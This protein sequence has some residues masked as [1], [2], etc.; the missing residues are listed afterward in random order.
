MDFKDRLKYLI[1]NK[2]VNGRKITP[3]YLGKNTSVSR[4]S[5]ENYISGKQKPTINNANIIAQFFNVSVDWLLSGKDDIDNSKIIGSYDA[6]ELAQVPFISIASTAGFVET[7][8]EDDTIT[9][10]I[11]VQGYTQE[12][13]TQNGYIAI[14]VS[15]HSMEPT[16]KDKARILCKRVNIGDWDY[17][18][19]GIYVIGY[20][21]D[22]LVTKRVK[23]NDLQTKG[24]LTLYSDNEEYGVLTVK[25]DSI[26]CIWQGIEIIRQKLI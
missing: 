15:G 11:A 18:H 8:C 16:I 7:F 23:E 2:K 22:M 24:T 26:R 17:I 14:E 13:I 10:T 5:I 21:L 20:G 12:E 1:D 25:K 3:Y 19:P 4:Q 9:D 6:N